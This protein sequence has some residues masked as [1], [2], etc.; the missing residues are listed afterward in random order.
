M[1]NSLNGSLG[2]SFGQRCYDVDV[3]PGQ[4]HPY[5]LAGGQSARMGRDKALL[6]YSGK[7]LLEFI[8]AELASAFG[9]AT[10]VGP[11]SRY[12]SLRLPLIED[13]HPGFGPLSGIEAALADCET[14]SRADWALIVACDMPNLRNELCREIARLA[15]AE[16]K[17]KIVMPLSAGG[18]PEPLCAA[19]HRSILPVIRKSLESGIFKVM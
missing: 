8:H 17:A 7:T 11:A 15:L 14:N 16:E 10:V 6:P 4:V 2:G 18:Q 5:V 13:L 9:S 19:Y 3:T 1:C 12:A